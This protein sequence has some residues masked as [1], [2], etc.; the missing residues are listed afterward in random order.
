VL[1]Q[2]NPNSNV[3]SSRDIQVGAG[4]GSTGVYTLSAGVAQTTG[5]G[6]MFVGRDGG[7][8]TFN[9]SGTG[10]LSIKG[11]NHIGAFFGG[12]GN[13]SMVGGAANVNDKT[14][15][16]SFGGTGSF[17]ISGGTYTSGQFDVGGSADGGATGLL[18]INGGAIVSNNDIAVGYKPGASGTVTQTTGSFTQNGGWAFVG[19]SGGAGTYN[20]SGGSF[21]SAGQVNVAFTDVG[22]GSLPGG[23][24]TGVI[25][26]TGGVFSSGE[27]MNIGRGGGFGDP[28]KL[29]SATYNLS[30]GT[31]IVGATTDPNNHNRDLI[32]GADPNTSGLMNQAGGGVFV[33]RWIIVGNGGGTGTYTQSAGTA[34]SAGWLRVGV[35]GELD[36]G[37][38]FGDGGVG[39][40]NLSGTAALTVGGSDSDTGDDQTEIGVGAL[41]KQDGVTVAQGKGTMNVSGTVDMGN[42]RVM[43]GEGGGAGTFNQTGGIVAVQQ[44][45]S[46]GHSSGTVGSGTVTGTG[47]YNLGGGRLAVAGDLNIGDLAGS[48]GT[49]N[50]SGGTGSSN[51]L[52]VGRSG[53]GVYNQSGGAFNTGL[54]SGT[55]S[56]TVSG[57]TFT[58]DSIHL[59]S[60]NIGPA[61][62]VAQHANGGSFGTSVVNALSITG[63]GKWNLNDNDLIVDYTGASPFTTVQSYIKSGYAGGSWNGNGLNSSAAAAA[64][65]SAH[66]TGLG[67]AE[68]S[69][70]GIGAGGGT[71][72]GQAVDNTSVLVRY[73]YSGDSNIDGTVNLTD[74]TFLAAN[75]NKVGGATW[76]QGDYNYDGNVDLTDFTFLASNFNQTL[77]SD[78]S[79]SLGTPVPEPISAALLAIAG[80]GLMLRHR[81][82]R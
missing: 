14:V 68:A 55:G 34:Q 40:Y 64:A 79:G 58:N 53:T 81:R 27:L 54:V 25:N 42:I 47:L 71:F 39:T 38:H 78:G 61:G 18:K 35:A 28:T 24:T 70:V 80:S 76:L 6:W 8:G 36:G 66:R 56:F 49:L 23:T 20:I 17:T 67:Y 19:R 26:Q 75:F 30:N 63:T 52:Y 2:S 37:T 11:Q 74:F 29:G 44:F 33:G 21:A 9:L 41:F 65:S 45:M 7:T 72:S 31:V 59:P 48:S 4:G 16:G 15:V 62:N 10:S 5:G 1:N 60:V 73:V 82:A 43:I 32:V 3:A 12:T 46:V 77:A 51:T 13:F 69:S 22:D 57:G 50:V